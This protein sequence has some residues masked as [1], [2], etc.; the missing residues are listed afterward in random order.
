[1]SES[2]MRKGLKMLRDA[3]DTTTFEG[4]DPDVDLPRFAVRDE[5]LAAAVDARD[6]V[7][8]KMA[9]MAAH[10]TQITTDGPFFALSNNMGAIA[11]GVEYFQLAKGTPGPLGP[12]GLETD[13][14]AGL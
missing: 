6:L 8:R 5:D 4:L 1:M 9:A 12:D 2:L 3:G 14:F 7:D 11:W 10:A 13:L